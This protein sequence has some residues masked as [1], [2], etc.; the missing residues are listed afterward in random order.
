[1]KNTNRKVLLEV[2]WLALT[3]GAS[4]ASVVAA[5]VPVAGDVPVAVDRLRLG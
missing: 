4:S 3:V 2:I 5:P 1:M